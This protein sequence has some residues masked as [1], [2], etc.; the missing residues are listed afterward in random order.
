MLPAPFTNI[1]AQ[2]FFKKAS[3]LG[4]PFRGEAQAG[5]AAYANEVR[6]GVWGGGSRAKWDQI[7]VTIRGFVFFFGLHQSHFTL[8]ALFSLRAA[9]AHPH[10]ILTLWGLNMACFY[11]P[12]LTSILFISSAKPPELGGD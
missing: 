3:L 9:R 6:K 10:L 11:E 4:G 1:S 12:I 8:V 5:F 7:E 2:S